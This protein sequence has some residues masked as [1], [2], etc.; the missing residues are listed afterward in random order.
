MK[1]EF[2]EFKKLFPPGI[3]AVDCHWPFAHGF[4]RP[5]ATGLT[6]KCPACTFGSHENKNQGVKNEF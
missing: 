2:Y 4:A 3:E 1:S 6:A 5:A